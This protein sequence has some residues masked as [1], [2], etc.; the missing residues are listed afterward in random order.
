M[1]GPIRFRLAVYPD[2]DFRHLKSF[3]ASNFFYAIFFVGNGNSLQLNVISSALFIG[4]VSSIWFSL[5][6]RNFSATEK[7]TYPFNRT[8][9]V[10]WSLARQAKVKNSFKS[11]RTCEKVIN[12][13]QK[14]SQR[15]QIRTA[16]RHQMVQ[17]EMKFELSLASSHWHLTYILWINY[18]MLSFGGLC[19]PWCTSHSC[20]SKKAC[21]LSAVHSGDAHWLRHFQ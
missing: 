1:F 20:T 2:G 12:G 9:Q 16:C 3:F 7:W 18:Q 6:L 15:Q 19:I 5:H 13:K 17:Q 8:D 14:H 4:E 21:W 10:V 11:K